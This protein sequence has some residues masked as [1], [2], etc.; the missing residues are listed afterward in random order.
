MMNSRGVDWGSAPRGE[1][2]WLMH[3]YSETQRKFEQAQAAG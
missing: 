1:E 2:N 3:L